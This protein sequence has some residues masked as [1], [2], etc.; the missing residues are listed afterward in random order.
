MTRKKDHEQHDL[1]GFQPV[2]AALPE[3]AR[4]IV[5]RPRRTM[6]V[7]QSAVTIS[8]QGRP[9]VAYQASVHYWDTDIR[10]LRHNKNFILAVYA[11]RG[12][13][14]RLNGRKPSAP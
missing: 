11:A 7:V 8:E 13:I 4:S 9:D 10:H 12:S 14:S 2:S 5:K 1:P 3:A 6:R